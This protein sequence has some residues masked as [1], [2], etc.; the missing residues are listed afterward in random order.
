MAN[1]GRWLTYRREIPGAKLR[2]F[3]FPFGGGGASTFFSWQ[4]GMPAGVEIC[5]V[6]PPGRESRFSEAPITRIPEM[7]SLLVEVLS[8]YLD[9]PFSLYGHSVGALTAFELA[10]QLRRQGLR[11]PELL[12]ASGHPSPDLSRRR[13]RISH[14]ARPEFMDALRKD[15]EVSHALLENQEMMD[16]IFPALR[17]DYELVETYI[18]QDESPL[19]IPFSIFGGSRDPEATREEI[20][21]WRKH[22]TSTFRSRVLEGDH[23]FINT[24]REALIG[25]LATD[26]AQMPLLRS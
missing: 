2:L 18:Y 1:S 9:G 8:P 7:I 25:E 20:L 12:F 22:T 21:A 6:Q 26:L 11:S 16:L 19:N 15:F 4:K 3:C 24:T 5:P 23:M 10:R 17:A 13:P 14:L